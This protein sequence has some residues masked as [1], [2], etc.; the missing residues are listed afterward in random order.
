M[1]VL[2]VSVLLA[3]GVAGRAE[4]ATPPT[5]PESTLNEFI[6]E[7]K[8]ISE[9]ISAAPKPDCGR[10]NDWHQI[11]VMA[12]LAAGLTFVGWRIVKGLRR[13]VQDT[14]AASDDTRSEPPD[15]VRR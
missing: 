15:R 1:R 3:F 7:D 8:P 12:V 14:A 2:L 10:D 6:P 11:A 13:T 5:P 4:A 9:C